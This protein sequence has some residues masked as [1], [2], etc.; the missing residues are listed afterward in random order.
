MTVE[1]SD[2]R[3]TTS[4]SSASPAAS[5]KAAMIGWPPMAAPIGTPTMTGVVSRIHGSAKAPAI[6]AMYSD[7]RGM[8]SSR[9]RTTFPASREG[10]TM[11]PKMVSTVANSRKYRTSATGI[12]H[13]GSPR[14]KPPVMPTRNRPMADGISRTSVMIGPSFSVATENRSRVSRAVVRSSALMNTR[15]RSQTNAPK[16]RSMATASSDPR[17]AA[18]RRPDR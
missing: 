12:R 15:Q 14:P 9:N 4:S 6:C 17:A 5:V 10:R 8:G 1:V 11:G 13:D 7:R 2:V 3:P 18:R 16:M